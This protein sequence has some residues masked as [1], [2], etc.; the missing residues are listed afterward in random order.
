MDVIVQDMLKDL[1]GPNT[2][3]TRAPG[4]TLSLL[5]SSLPCDQN[6]L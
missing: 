1:I 6:C 5:L 2:E 3:G 4:T